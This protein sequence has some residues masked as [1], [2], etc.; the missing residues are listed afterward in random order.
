MARVEKTTCKSFRM[1]FLARYCWNTREV[2]M[3]KVTTKV[4]V[5]NCQR[6]NLLGQELKNSRDNTKRTPNLSFLLSRRSKESRSMGHTSQSTTRSTLSGTRKWKKPSKATWDKSR[7]CRPNTNKTS[8]HIKNNWASSCLKMESTQRKLWT[9]GKSRRPSQ[10][11]K[12]T[13]KLKRLNRKSR[14]SRKGMRNSGTKLGIRKWK[15]WWISS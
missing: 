5:A 8:R 13:R 11:R 3:L 10:T 2:A 4:R 15:L 12:T 14:L 1:L 6:L 9:R 7:S